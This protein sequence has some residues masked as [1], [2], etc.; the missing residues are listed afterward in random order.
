MKIYIKGHNFRYETEKLVRIFLPFEKV[1]FSE[2]LDDC[3]AELTLNLSEKAQM[4]ARLTLEGK[5]EEQSMETEL[6][7][8]KEYERILAVLL[9]KCFEK[10]SGYS[11]RWGILTG[12]RPAKLYNKLRVSQGEKKADEYFKEKLLVS[13]GKIDLCKSAVAGEKEIIDLSKEKSFSLYIGIPFCPSRCSYCS[14]VSHSVEQAKKLIPEYV[15]LLCEEIKITGEI[16]RKLGLKLETIYF[17]GGTPTTLSA[18]Q[19]TEVMSA[20][21]SSFDL[22]NIREYTI[23]AGRPDTITR[24]KLEAIKQGGADRISINPQTMNDA[25]LQNIG[26]R[27]T[28][29]ETVAALR[30]AKEVS[31]KNINMDVIAGL[32]GDNL[33]SF[34]NTINE[35]LALDPESI[36]IHTLCLKKAANMTISGQIQQLEFGEETSNMLDYGK[37]ALEK[38][39]YFPYY[40]YRQSKMVGNLENVGYSKKGFEGLYNV[41]I[42]DETHTILSCGASAVT[43]LRAYN[44]NR[45]ERIYN[46]KYPYE[47]ISRFGEQIQRKEKILEFYDY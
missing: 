13:S 30:I 3:D 19:I 40:M 44:E 41:Y 27:H 33:V 22:S 6:D 39:G 5:T 23:E 18:Q 7:S 17:G 14:F 8:D 28:A 31:F 43:K 26:R 10:L 29:A 25:V 15:K 24:E 45:I 35:I 20:V 46:F 11:S 1:E 36:T 47:Y 32:P 12:V 2:V 16:A 34:K 37:T 9:Y 38:E 42:M 4:Y 21:K